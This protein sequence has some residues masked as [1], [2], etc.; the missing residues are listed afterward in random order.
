MDNM[1]HSQSRIQSFDPLLIPKPNTISSN[2]ILLGITFVH[3]FW[4]ENDNCKKYIYC[5]TYQRP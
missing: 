3:L 4:F 2:Q 1:D 5:R